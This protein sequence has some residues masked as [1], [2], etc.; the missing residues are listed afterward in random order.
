MALVKD[1]TFSDFNE[2]FGMMSRIAIYADGICHHPEW[3]NVYNNLKVSECRI[4]KLTKTTELFLVTT[5]LTEVMLFFHLSSAFFLRN[6]K[7]SLF[8]LYHVL[9]RSHHEKTSY[10][11][12]TA[13]V[14]NLD[15]TYQNL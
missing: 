8:L 2:A 1:F 10:L 6:S 4:F 7:F 14:R 13:L 3:F 11:S 15:S 12:S 9:I 5:R